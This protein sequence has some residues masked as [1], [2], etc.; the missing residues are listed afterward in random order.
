MA[1]AVIEIAQH[2]ELVVVLDLF[3]DVVADLAVE[4][5]VGR[6]II[7]H[8]IGH[9]QRAHFR[10]YGCGGARGAAHR[11]ASRFD[12]VHDLELL[13]DQGFA[14]ELH[15][16][17]AFRLRGCFLRHPVERDRGRFR[18]RVDVR[19]Y[20]L[21]R[22]GL[23]EGRRAAGGENAGHAG[24]RAQQRAAIER[25]AA[26]GSRH[27]RSSK[28]GFFVCGLTAGQGKTGQPATSL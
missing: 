6:G 14:E 13:R 7:L 21:F 4:H 16:K 19:E 11:D 28:A 23:R 26:R 18:D 9:E 12:R 5:G 25:E 15:V 17:R 10:K 24:A 1:E 8:Q 3:A 22:R 20:E 27:R 2:L